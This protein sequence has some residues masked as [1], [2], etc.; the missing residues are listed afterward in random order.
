MS[1]KRQDCKGQLDTAHT[2]QER[3]NSDFKIAAQHVGRGFA[4]DP[5]CL[6]RAGTQSREILYDCLYLEASLVRYQ[7]GPS[8]K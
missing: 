2:I 4:M 6:S 7:A 5:S 3:R 1:C 8:E